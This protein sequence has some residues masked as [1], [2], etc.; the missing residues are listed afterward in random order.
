MKSKPESAARRTSLVILI[1][2]E[3]FIQ[4][5]LG[6]MGVELSSNYFFKYSGKGL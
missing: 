1:R 5:V 4:A 2:A 3:L 6:E